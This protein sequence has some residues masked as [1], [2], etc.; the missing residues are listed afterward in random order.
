MKIR[1]GRNLTLLLIPLLAGCTGLQRPPEP[2]ADVDH[3]CRLLFENADTEIRRAGVGDAGAARVAGFPWLRTSRFLSSFRH[4]VED[5]EQFQ[6]WIAQ[7][8]EL[9]R[10]ARGFELHNLNA[11]FQL[12]LQQNWQPAAQLHGLPEQVDQAFAY[13]RTLLNEELL[14]EELLDDADAQDVLREAAVVPDAYNTWQRVLGLYPLAS[15]IA[16][17][18]VEALHNKLRG[19]F[20]G[21]TPDTASWHYYAVPRSP[22]DSIPAQVA[23]LVRQLDRDTL[24]I[25]RPD[26]ETR[27]RLLDAHAP[28]W[29]VDTRGS[30]DRPGA[31]ELDARHQP[32]I[33]TDEGVE[34]RWISWTRFGDEILLQLNYALWFPERPPVARLD[35]VAGK[36]DGVIWRVTLEREGRVLAYD[37]IHPCGCYYTLF[38]GEG[39][40]SA[41]L[42]GNQEP[43]FAPRH[44]PI[45]GRDER[46]LLLLET[47]TR[48]FLDVTISAWPVP[49]SQLSPVPSATLRSLPLPDGSR[50]SV[51]EP[52]GL[53]PVSQ[54]PERF[55]LWPL[56]VPSAGSM[57]QPGTQ[58][59][60]F[61][62]RRHFDDAY[63]LQDLL[64]RGT[65]E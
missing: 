8:A 3:T 50:A 47:G 19:K 14:N 26:S 25:P 10:E 58:A 30:A 36:L 2:V 51:F 57:R 21:A 46:V 40:E 12:R 56:G 63:L 61:I 65:A 39:W 13:C 15:R 33:D 27:H 6:A 7:L 34:Y 11:A 32:V 29:A 17:S 55:F 20:D 42:A 43:I 31:L 38:P 59:I 52:D 48:Y 35:I 45:P 49:A 23:T 60:A 44:A 37:S 54:R 16:R 28:V 22:D 5:P 41:R 62:G 1:V 18:R 9:D 4:Q 53:I 24:G 64:I